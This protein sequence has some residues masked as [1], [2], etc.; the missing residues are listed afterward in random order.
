MTPMSK[1]ADRLALAALLVTVAAVA[2]LGFALTS[3]AR[4]T[5]S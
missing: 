4:E 3:P 2:L 5:S 1:L